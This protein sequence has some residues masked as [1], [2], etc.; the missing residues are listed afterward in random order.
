MSYI[1]VSKAYEPFWNIAAEEYYCSLAAQS[2]CPCFIYGRTKLRR[3]RQNQNPWAECNLKAME[4]DGVTLMRR[5]TG[6]G[7]VYHD[8]GNINYSFCMPRE[9]YSEKKQYGIIISAISSLGINAELS[10]R[11]DI[12]VDGKKVSGSA[13]LHSNG[14]SL[15]HGTLLVNSDLSVFSKYLTPSADKLEAKGVKSVS[16]RVTNLGEYCNALTPEKLSDAICAE[17]ENVFGGRRVPPEPDTLRIGELKKEYES[18]DFRF[19]RTPPFEITLDARLGFGKLAIGLSLENGVIRDCRVWSDMLNP[20]FPPALEA[21]L[22]NV[23]FEKNTL[24][25]AASGIKIEPEARITAD[26]LQNCG[27]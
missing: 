21:A 16:S 7:A 5:K 18:W 9:I 19:G 13:F 1:F 22:K 20:D 17:F 8:I 3:N 24:A 27:I 15:H 25:A 2:L 6:G 23:R 4:E 26:W 10:G 11:N 12:T 14:A